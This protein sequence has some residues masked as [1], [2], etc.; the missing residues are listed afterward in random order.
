MYDLCEKLL[1]INK[2]F[3]KSIND[4]PSIEV[5]QNLRFD[6]N[7]I[8]DYSEPLCQQIYLM[9]YMYAYSFEFYYVYRLVFETLYE[10]YKAT[11]VLSIG[12][13]S[14]YDYWAL[15]KAYMDSNLED[16]TGVFYYIGIDKV[17]W[18]YTCASEKY[19]KVDILKRDFVEWIRENPNDFSN[20]DF[21][22]FP[23]SIGEFSEEYF[24]TLLLEIKQ[25][26]NRLK[27]DRVV[28]IGSFRKTQSSHQSDVN[29][30]ESFVDTLVSA[31]GYIKQEK[32]S[33][34]RVFRG[35][36][37]R[38]IYEYNHFPIFPKSVKDTLVNLDVCCN[39][40]IKNGHHCSPCECEESLVF[41]NPVTTTSC[42]DFK[43]VVL[44]RGEQ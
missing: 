28:I 26:Q 3:I 25:P 41:R 11:H 24:K 16:T 32:Q 2:D 13:G 15:K 8:P 5:L 42:I 17:N 6:Y 12:C 22:F 37:N 35:D 36:N 44:K 30:F 40:Y 4:E 21:I 10:L 19:D 38:Y 14:A 39:R 23:K 33:S 31:N 18:L 27:R 34:D 1:E 20:R 9:R 7:N 29:R 43:I